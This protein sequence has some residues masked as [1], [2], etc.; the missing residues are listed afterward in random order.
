MAEESFYLTKEGYANLERELQI[1]V[2]E[3]RQ[4]MAEQLKDVHEDTE[5]GEEATFFDVVTAKERLEEKIN[6]LRRVL[7]RA[8]I[9]GE[10]RDPLR[11]DPGE[12]VTVWDFETKEEVMFDLLGGA[13]IT[14]GRYGVSIKS[15]VGQALLG[16]K[17]GDVI[18]VEVPDGIARFAI[19][20]IEPIPPD[21]A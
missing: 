13:E 20:K 4:K 8:E 5:Y 21:S 7:A 9:I 15:P 19:R 14:T 6:Y 18:E 2:E 11:I 12:R 16:K 10:D 1:L 3:D 17:V